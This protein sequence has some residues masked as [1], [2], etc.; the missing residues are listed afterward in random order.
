MLSVYSWIYTQESLLMSSGD[1]EVPRMKPG[2]NECKALPVILLLV[3][4]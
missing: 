3:P 2:S 1:Y 4:P